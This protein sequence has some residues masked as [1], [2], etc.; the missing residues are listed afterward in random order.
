MLARGDF[1]GSWVVKRRLGS[2][3]FGVVYEVANVYTQVE[4][5]AKLEKAYRFNS[6]LF[7]ESALLKKLGFCR[8]IPKFFEIFTT[9]CKGEVYH[10]LVLE[11]LSENLDAVFRSYGYNFTSHEVVF[12]VRQIVLLLKLVHGENYIHRDVKPQNFVLGVGANRNRVYII[13]F[14]L[15]QL[16]RSEGR[17]IQFSYQNRVVGTIKFAS[18]NSLL[19]FQQSRRDDLESC[20]WMLKYF[21][22]RSQFYRKAFPVRQERLSVKALVR[23]KLKV[24]E[25]LFQKE[26]RTTVDRFILYTT[27]LGF[28][29]NPDYSYLLSVL[30]VL[31][32]RNGVVGLCCVEKLRRFHRTNLRCGKPT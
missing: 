27:F 30:Q 15:S 32:E 1:C 9:V 6:T 20:S 18:I 19:G 17:H 29:E 13:D 11:L 4:A 2:G 14:G 31:F 28:T 25:E 23:L 5:A 3:S 8:G 26:H 10:V 21:C 12:F 7:Y 22:S 16:Y 24:I